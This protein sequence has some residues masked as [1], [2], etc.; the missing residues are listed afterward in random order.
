MK[1]ALGF[2]ISAVYIL[3][4]AGCST[5]PPPV[6]PV[7][8][9]VPLP[10]VSQR[11]RI[12]GSEMLRKEISSLIR[13][14]YSDT[15]NI[16][17][18]YVTDRDVLGDPSECDDN[19]YGVDMGKSV[20]YGMC[21][22]NVPKRHGVGGFEAAPN[23]RADTHKY[24]RVLSHTPMD[25]AALA[26]YI[27]SRK[28]T[29][30][31]VF[32]H[33]FNVKFQEAVMRSAQ[34]AY[35]LKFQGPVILFTWPAGA[36]TGMLDSARIGK[37]YELNRANASASLP[38][39]MALL[40]LLAAQDVTVHMMVHSMGHQVMIPALAGVAPVVNK[41]FIGELILN[42]PDFAVKDFQRLAPKMRQLAERITV[43]CSYNDNAIA[44]SESYNKGRR[45]GACELVDSVD[46]V[47]VGEID[48][49]ALGIGGLGHGYYA[50]RPILTDVYQVL[51]GVEADRRLFIRKS[52]PGS[53]E[54]Y[55]LRP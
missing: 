24:Y 48:A 47:N 28:P 36:G 4:L 53:T 12:Y 23:P 29:D 42:A 22:V 2:P 46:I 49:P 40:K 6:N 26:A 14:P 50:G 17:V 43:Y 19:A 34:I 7:E 41:Q 39:A 55:Y 32:V 20:S 13:E 30:V 16:D 15:R 33:G 44:A 25:E 18:L 38:Q 45:M 54:N 5:T 35:D 27:Q 52:E 11:V 21:R 31:L 51:T 10:V 1:R 9:P 3:A 37:T 8:T